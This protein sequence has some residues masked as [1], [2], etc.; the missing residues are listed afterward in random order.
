MTKRSLASPETTDRSLKEAL[1]VLISSTRS[2]K[3]VLPLT[4]IAKWLEIAVAKLG[5]Y[6]AVAQRIGL[7]P[8]MLRQFSNVRRLPESVQ[9]LFE[10][11]QLDSVD[12]CTHLAMLPETEQI[13]LATALTSG[14]IDTKDLRAIVQLHQRDRSSSIDDLLQRVK[15][16]K[17]RHEYVAEFV[18][19]GAKT[20]AALLSAFEKHIPPKEIVRLEVNG[21][22][23][24]LV[25]TQK[26]KQ[27]LS[28][29]ARIL[30]V[31]IKHVIPNF[32]RDSQRS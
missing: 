11:R 4:E 17:T 32:L 19:R 3:R 13:I 1:A 20:R 10:S 27:A 29:T 6:E 21:A 18:V 5:S 16:S 31:P 12:A 14:E 28:N 25:L 2:K 24:R 30:K 8:H 23:G 26:G 7:S 15:E 22:F 9:Q